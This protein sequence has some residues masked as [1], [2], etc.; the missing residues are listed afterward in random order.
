[1]STTPLRADLQ[2]IADWIRPNSRVLDLGCGEGE[3]LDY[4]QREKGVQAYGIELDEERIAVALRRG[5]SVLQQDL[6]SGLRQFASNSVDTVVLSLTLQAVH[7]PRELLLEMLRVG[8]EGIVTRTWGTGGP[9]GS[10]AWGDEC[11]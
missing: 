4:L 7:Y 6:D 1:M 10:W 11:R 5:I 8:R 2:I 3:L 9:A